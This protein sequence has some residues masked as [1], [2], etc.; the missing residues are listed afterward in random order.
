M[1][2]QIKG[3]NDTIS[4]AD[5]TMTLEGQTLAFTNENITGVSTMAFWVVPSDD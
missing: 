3:S 4:A 5:G 2:I 1:G